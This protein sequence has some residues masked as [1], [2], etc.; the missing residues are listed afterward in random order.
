M[1]KFVIRFISWGL[2]FG[3]LADP[4]LCTG[5]VSSPHRPIAV[6]LFTQEALGPTSYAETPAL[7]VGGEQ[8]AEET[9][10]WI[11][12]T[13][14]LK[15]QTSRRG[16]LFS[17]ALAPFAARSSFAQPALKMDQKTIRDGVTDLLK[18]ASDH[19]KTRFKASMDAN[20]FIDQRTLINECFENPL[21]T[22]FA[23]YGTQ[24]PEL[25]EILKHAQR[26]GGINIEDIFDGLSLFYKRQN[27]YFEA[28]LIDMPVEAGMIKN[29]LEMSLFDVTSFPPGLLPKVEGQQPEFIAI[30]NAHI[31]GV[32]A[33]LMKATP[34]AWTYSRHGHIKIVANLDR[35]IEESKEAWDFMQTYQH[36]SFEELTAE[37]NKALR[38]HRL[39]D[40][41][42][43]VSARLFHKQFGSLLQL[44]QSSSFVLK[45]WPMIL[46]ETIEHEIGHFIIRQ[47][48]EILANVT[49]V[50][51]RGKVSEALAG[52]YSVA[53]TEKPFYAMQVL[54]SWNMSTKDPQYHG[55]GTFIFP[56]IIDELVTSQ[57]KYYPSLH[58]PQGFN[59]KDE[60]H[61]NQMLGQLPELTPKEMNLMAERV[62]ARILQLITG[63]KLHGALV[64][65]KSN[66]DPET[67]VLASLLG[68]EIMTQHKTE[69]NTNWLN[70]PSNHGITTESSLG[71]SDLTIAGVINFNIP[72]GADLP[73]DWAEV[74]Q[75][76]ISTALSQTDPKHLALLTA[77]PLTFKIVPTLHDENG[78][79]IW[80]QSK[81][82]ERTILIHA[83]LLDAMAK[84]NDK[85]ANAG[86]AFCAVITQMGLSFFVEHPDRIVS[87]TDEKSA[88]L[89]KYAAPATAFLDW[90]V[91]LSLMQEMGYTTPDKNLKIKLTLQSYLALNQ[92]VT[93]KGFLSHLTLINHMGKEQRPADLSVHKMQ[94]ELSIMQYVARVSASEPPSVT[95]PIHQNIIP[96]LIE[97]LHLLEEGDESPKLDGQYFAIYL[98]LIYTFMPPE[99][100]A[101]LVHAMLEAASAE[102]GN[103]KIETIVRFI[104]TPTAQP[105]GATIP[106]DL[107]L[108]SGVL[109]Q[110][111]P[112]FIALA[113]KGGW[114]DIEIYLAQFQRLRKR[115]FLLS[116]TAYGINSDWK[117]YPLE[118]T[119][120]IETSIRRLPHAWISPF[121]VAINLRSTM[122]EADLLNQGLA[123]VGVPCLI[124]PTHMN[125]KTLQHTFWHEYLGHLV[126]NRVFDILD[127]MWILNNK[128]WRLHLP[129]RSEVLK[130]GKDAE[131]RLF[132]EVIHTDGSVEK[133]KPESYTLNDI[134]STYYSGADFIDPVD[135]APLNLV[136]ANHVPQTWPLEIF[137]AY[138]QPRGS[139]P[140][141]GQ[142][143]N[144][145][146]RLG[147]DHIYRYTHPMEEVAEELALIWDINTKQ[148]S[149]NMRKLIRNANFQNKHGNGTT[150]PEAFHQADSSLGNFLKE[151]MMVVR[152]NGRL[153]FYLHGEE[154]IEN[155]RRLYPE[156]TQDPETL[157]WK[158]PYSEEASKNLT[159]YERFRAANP[160]IPTPSAIEGRATNGF[161]YF[162]VRTV[163]PVP[164]AMGLV[165]TS[166]QVIRALGS[167]AATLFLLLHQFLAPPISP[168]PAAHPLTISA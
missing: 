21:N 41:G 43:L 148:I 60:N 161:Q 67:I 163:P 93:Q 86:N 104:T 28:S 88:T 34:S 8:D 121:P 84:L 152:E 9:R 35:A 131:G 18:K 92:I 17:G 69:E 56:L 4:Q 13:T 48:P 147:G 20:Q 137:A 40:F 74:M 133:K 39:V 158:I 31:T 114:A 150:A 49:P 25:V 14:G 59:P 160:L 168:K 138:N 3:L 136:A 12:I 81:G 125:L 100:R 10:L 164:A 109:S 58:I 126:A 90:E 46:L 108:N 117:T 75:K 94:L 167:Y 154:T 130:V 132:W 111:L 110:D 97:N 72:Q 30:K 101:H 124:L 2:I 91:F 134:A 105:N 7:T 29:A 153:Y 149:L 103:K 37:Q 120:L 166:S 115:N 24:I 102:S 57:A 113:K 22:L 70:P 61:L 79:P 19:Y 95:D 1:R 145:G 15:T 85:Q 32:R 44:P 155:M 76:S 82:P 26:N 71:S 165:S 99:N 98:D 83:G 107:L 156:A 63:N 141:L 33:M 36:L 142:P 62:H 65:P 139:E 80:V 162:P 106:L 127:W 89:L 42:H 118:I 53:R 47:K 123:L 73:A 64:P 116:G 11:G 87:Y 159:M 151:K 78:N 157:L 135:E 51:L 140:P 122:D 66:L 96:I 119:N 23:R 16:F 45:V 128:G 55:A 77:G 143:I 38:E 6:S 129:G 112:M 52:I 144:F 50:A 68:V 27:M 146:A 54:I 5:N